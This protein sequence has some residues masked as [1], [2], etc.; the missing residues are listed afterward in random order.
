M[1]L[2]LQ[3]IL[4]DKDF[5]AIST[6]ALEALRKVPDSETSIQRLANIVLR[7]YALTVKVLRTAN[8]AHYRRS[9][10]HI[11]SAAHAML[12]L[13]A[14]TVRNL[15]G[16]LLLFEH[17]RAR[18]NGL[19]ELML[20][21][22]LTANHAREVAMRRNLPDPEEANLC[23]M[24]R[25]LGE[26]LI[27][28]YFPRDYARI[29]K[30]MEERRAPQPTAAFD[31]LGFRFEELGEAMARHWGIPES[32]CGAI[33]SA[34]AQSSNDLLVITA[35]AHDL[36]AA[37]YRREADATRDSVAEVL[38]RYARRL[39][40]TREEVGEIL[41]AAMR[42]TKATF[43]SANVSLDALTLRR[44]QLQALEALGT[45]G[46]DAVD[47]D[48]G[49]DAEELDRTAGPMALR[50]DLAA[51]VKRMASPGSGEE[52]SK[53]ILMTLEAAF[54]GG[55]FSRVVLC[56]ITPDRSM[57]NARY[58]L[59]AGVEAA[60]DRFSCEVTS[61]TSPIAQAMN[62]P[63]SVAVPTERDLSPSEQR[64]AQTVG[65]S[66]WLV[67]P[68]VVGHKPLGT[69]YCDRDS[70]S[71]PPDAATVAFVR[72]LCQEV[73]A[74]IAA[75]SAAEVPKPETATAEYKRDA[76]LRIFAGESVDAVS[77][78]LGVAVPLLER[79]R[80]EFL[81]GAMSKLSEG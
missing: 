77:A 38:G 7:D 24:F 16:S 53:V 63:R 44:Q 11:R 30:R 19:K 52:L 34:S 15:A 65:A 46:Q 4:A 81:E 62:P 71:P 12:L 13:G 32:T 21:S 51:E 75:R 33:R 8:S 18:S 79:W 20:L 67:V 80:R 70:S 61:R 54:R 68:L 27:A 3:A 64:F 2:R 10:K 56:L 29:L 73:L 14:G 35:F 59:G 28:A 5:P 9:E 69:L 41:E 50:D 58:G 22:L 31:I 6:D 17:Y 72:A 74:G 42:E 55:P 39:K 45:G 25:N 60:L 36:T 40:L 43:A 23:G 48:D 57:L 49:A 76:V 47:G 26:V 1:E 78:S 66:S 37:V